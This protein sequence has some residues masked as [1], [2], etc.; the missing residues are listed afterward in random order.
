[1][2]LETAVAAAA[3]DLGS[4][5]DGKDLGLSESGELWVRGR[6]D[7]F[8]YGVFAGGVAAISA[9]LCHGREVFRC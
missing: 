1:M 2:M 4:V 5:D 7:G 3:R 8:C 9:G 6:L